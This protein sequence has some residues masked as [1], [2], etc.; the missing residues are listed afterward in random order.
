M[1]KK[2]ENRRC[3]LRLVIFY[4]LRLVGGGH[5][6]KIAREITSPQKKK[7]IIIPTI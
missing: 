7:N 1:L 3:N 4:I 6:K 5:Y 2:I